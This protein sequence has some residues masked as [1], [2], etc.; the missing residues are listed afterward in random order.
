M[1]TEKQDPALEFQAQAW[2][3]YEGLVP[4]VDW[5]AGAHGSEAARAGVAP[6]K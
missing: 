1:S 2:E 4:H 6:L 5:E 3:Q